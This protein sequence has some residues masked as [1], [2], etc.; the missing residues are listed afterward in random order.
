MPDAIELL[1]ARLAPALV[2]AVAL[3]ALLWL[4]GLVRARGAAAALGWIG[5][6]FLVG[7]WPWA[8]MITATVA[9]AGS[10]SRLV[11]AARGA[12]TGPPGARGVTALSLVP[13]LAALAAGM[14][15]VAGQLTT[16]AVGA[17]AAAAAVWAGVVVSVEARGPRYHPLTLRPDTGSPGLSG[18]GLFAGLAAAAVATGIGILLQLLGPGMGAS[19][20]VGALAGLVTGGVPSGNAA[21]RLPERTA[22]GALVGAV[23]G[24]LLAGFLA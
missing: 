10:A 7:R 8:L 24:A 19:I 1:D 21:L 11:G 22:I 23:T 13:L 16:L 18:P 15:M 9:I 4:A 5:V 2:S 12:A 3:A 17:A 6:A 20:M 14:S